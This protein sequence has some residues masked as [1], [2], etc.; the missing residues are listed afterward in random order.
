MLSCDADFQSHDRGV[1]EEDQV[2]F[3]AELHGSVA[4]PG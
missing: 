3:L 2:E 4:E 1:S